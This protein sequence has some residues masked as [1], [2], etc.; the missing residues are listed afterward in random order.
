MI[1]TVNKS[2]RNRKLRAIFPQMWFRLHRNPR[3]I[4]S[5]LNILIFL[6]HALQVKIVS[7]TL[8]GC[9]KI[10][11]PAAPECWW[12]LGFCFER[13]EWCARGDAR[14]A[15]KHIEALTH[16]GG[17][18]AVINTHRCPP[19]LD[20]LIERQVRKSVSQIKQHIILCLCASICAAHRC[21]LVWSYGFLTKTWQGGHNRASSEPSCHDPRYQMHGRW[22][23]PKH[24]AWSQLDRLRHQL[25]RLVKEAARQTPSAVIALK[26]SGKQCL[27]YFCWFLASF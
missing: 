19:F 4:S 27:H 16:D 12:F 14:F 7:N 17:S 22:R 2:Y 24:F 15:C 5:R 23:H 13:R 21:S 18:A 8:T 25:A 1:K 6:V 10:T 26:T 9:N 3:N 20:N 11:M